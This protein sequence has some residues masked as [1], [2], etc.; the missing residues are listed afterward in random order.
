MVILHVK[1]ESE[2]SFLYE[3]NLDTL[4]EDTIK[5]LVE[6]YNGRL[7]V[8][9]I[10]L[11][12]ENILD[13]AVEASISEDLE[14]TNLN[15]EPPPCDQ[16]E[17]EKRYN[18]EKA[19]TIFSKVVAEA[20]GIISTTQIKSNVCLSQQHIQEAVTILKGG[21]DIIFP[22]GLSLNHPLR[23]EFE[24]REDLSGTQDE[25]LI[26][27]P[28]MTKIWFSSKALEE[29]NKLSKYFGKNEKTKVIVKLQPR[30]S[31]TPPR[32]P[33]LTEEEKKSIMMYEFKRREELK[34]LEEDEDN[35]YLDSEWAD[36]LHLKK[37][38]HGVN[39]INWKP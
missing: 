29:G 37:A 21:I 23:K 17:K 22:N 18:K 7:K 35:S 12:I 15:E 11:G 9:R 8:E 33:V 16:P 32:E 28:E 20:R 31:S 4:V 24:N 36:N 3:T 25:K 27:Y 14:N 1:R 30:G 10:C 26:L 39:K 38:F 34:K 5:S 19:S 2:S 6:V 13:S